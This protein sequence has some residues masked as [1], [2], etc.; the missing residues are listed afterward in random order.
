[1]R[2]FSRFS[3]T[4]TISILGMGLLIVGLPA[5]SSMA[6]S[7]SA[8]QDVNSLL[9]AL[10][11]QDPAVAMKAAQELKKNGF[12]GERPYSRPGRGHKK[13]ERGRAP[14]RDRGAFG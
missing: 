3:T 12:P 13:S 8:F 6:Q 1:M 7:P 5:R 14:D 10:Q 4:L 2:L 9:Q 11:S